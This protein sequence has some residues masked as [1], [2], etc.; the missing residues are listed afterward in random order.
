MAFTL[1]RQKHGQ[2]FY[3]SLRNGYV[4]LLPHMLTVANKMI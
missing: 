2:K 4:L 3:P 1:L